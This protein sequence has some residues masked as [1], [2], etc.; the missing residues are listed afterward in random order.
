MEI[1]CYLFEKVIVTGVAWLSSVRVV[2][3]SVYSENERNPWLYKV[4]NVFTERYKFL[5]ILF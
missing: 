5:F 4:K 1:I 2:R 3:H